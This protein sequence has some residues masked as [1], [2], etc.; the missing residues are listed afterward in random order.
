MSKPLNLEVM[1][2]CPAKVDANVCWE[3]VD[4]KKGCCGDIDNPRIITTGNDLKFSFNWAATGPLF[5]IMGPSCQWCMEVRLENLGSSSD[6]N[7][8][9]QVCLPHT[10]QGSYS[11]TVTF[12]A[13]T[14][15]S[16][17][18]DI[19]KPVVMLHLDCGGTMIVCGFEEFNAI[20]I[21]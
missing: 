13:G 11:G 5:D 16:Y 10:G 12:N 15:A 7:L 8:T 19:F 14:L 9:Q 17:S 20:H 2:P 6:P 4:N 21:Q 3:E 1:F 18:G